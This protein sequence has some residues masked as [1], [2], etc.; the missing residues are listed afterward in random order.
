MNLKYLP[1]RAPEKGKKEINPELVSWPEEYPLL[2]PIETHS[3]EKITQLT[4]RE[5]RQGS[6]ELADEESGGHAKMRPLLAD[7][8]EQ[9]PDDLRNLGALDYRNLSELV[10]SFL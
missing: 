10:G 2:S 9:S 4:L 7:L 6:L 3:G 1:R 8:S 5:P